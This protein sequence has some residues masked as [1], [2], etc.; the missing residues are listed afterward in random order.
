MDSENKTPEVEYTLR[1]FIKAVSSNKK[2]TLTEVG[3]SCNRTTTSLSN[4]F[5]RGECNTSILKDILQGMGEDLVI[6]TSNGQ[7]YKLK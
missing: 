5:S 7:K 2:M 4:I 3:T 1:E 6:I